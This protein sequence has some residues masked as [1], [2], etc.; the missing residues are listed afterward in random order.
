MAS[1]F[2]CSRGH[3]W[4]ADMA[5][6]EAAT[7]VLCPVCRGVGA[8]CTTPNGVN[9][10]PAEGETETIGLA[11]PAAAARA[12]LPVIAGYEV[13]EELGRGGMGVVYKARQLKLNRLVALKMVLAGAHAVSSDLLR[14]LA[15]AEAVA[16]LQ[17][18]NI[19]QVHEVGSHGGLPFISL[20]Y[21]DG[22]TLARK[23]KGTP[24]LPK[25]AAV[26][27]ATLG[28]AVQFAHQHGV[29]HRDLKPGN[30]LL[31]A[32][33]TPKIADFG[34]AK[35][36]AA[37][38][39]VTQTGAVL[40]TPSYMAPEQA[41]CKK[42]IGPAA[43]IYALG[44]ILYELLTGRPPFQA[45]TQL[46]TVL[47][48]V[49][50]EPVPPRRLQPKAPRDLETICLKCLQKEPRKRYA[51]AAALADDLDRFLGDRPILARPVG[52]LERTGRW[53]RRNPIVAGL[54]AT[55][56]AGA[57]V[58]VYFLNAERIE[59]FSNLHRAQA[60][61]ADLKVQ[62]Q[63]TSEAEQEK[64]DKL[65]QSYFDRAR[66]G[67]FSRQ[68]GQRLDGLDALAAAARIRPS[69]QLRDQAIACMALVDLRTVPSG[70]TLPEGVTCESFDPG[71]RRYAY[72]DKTGAVSVRSVGDGSEVAHR[73]PGGQ[74]VAALVFSPDG[75]LLAGSADSSLFVWDVERDQT[76][77]TL[78]RRPVGFDFSPDGR[79]AAVGEAGVVHL[80]D[81][82]LKRERMAFP[83][84]F[85]DQRL[86]FSPDGR[87]LAVTGVW[88]SSAVRVFDSETGAL[89]QE[90]ALPQTYATAAPTWHPDGERLAVGGA[91]GRVYL[92]HVPDRRM[93]AVLEGHAQDVIGA[94]FTPDGDHLLTAS[95]DGTARLWE[96]ATGR[97]LLTRVGGFTYDV[98]GDRPRLGYFT[99]RNRSI[100]FVELADDREFRSFAN[101]LSMGYGQY[102][103]A[104]L[105]PDG[106]LAAAATDDGVRLWDLASGRETTRLS[107]GNCHAVAFTPDGG[108]LLTSGAAGLLRW[109]IRV[110]P[111]APNGL[112]IGPPRTLDVLVAP[113][114]FQLAADGRTAA[115]VSEREQAVAVL[116]A[117]S[118]A[119]RPFRLYNPMASYVAISPD[120]RWA[121]SGG[122]HAPATR[123]WDAH[124]GRMVKEM[125]LGEMT[126][127]FFSPD[128]R[129]LITCRPEEYCFWDVETWQPGLR[130]P[131]EQEPYPG[132]AAFTGDGEL[133]ALELT[134]GV[135]GLLD[136]KSDR[137]VARLENPTHD[138]ASTL[139]F[140]ADGAHLMVVAPYDRTVHVWDLRR[141]R[142]HLAE[143]HLEG[144]WPAYPP[145]PPASEPVRVRQDD[146]LIAGPPVVAAPPPVVALPPLNPTHR[147]A[148]PQQIQDWIR[149]L[150][151]DDGKASAEA[152][153]ALVDVG[154]PTVAALKPAASGPDDGLARRAAEVIDQIAV[155]EALTPPRVRRKL[156][157][158]ASVAEVVA[159]LSNQS[160]VRVDYT[161]SRPADPPKKLTLDLDNIPFWEAIDR[162]CAAGD[163]TFAIQFGQNGARVQLS[164]GPR[165]R[166]EMIADA[167]PFRLQAMSWTSNRTMILSGKEPTAI[168]RLS[169]SLALQGRGDGVAG[170]GPL[171][172]QEAEDDAGQPRLMD[173]PPGP[174]PGPPGFVDPAS[175]LFAPFRSVLLKP[176]DRRGG[177]LKRLKGVLPVEVTTERRDLATATELDKAPGKTFR[178]DGVTLIVQSVQ[179]VANGPAGQQ[180]MMVLVSLDGG[181]DWAYDATSEG[182]EL[183]DGEGRRI[184]PAWVNVNHPAVPVRRSPWPA[185]LAVFG[186]APEAGFPGAVPWAVLALNAPQ[187]GW[188]A[189]AQFITPDKLDLTKAKLTFYHYRLLRTELP[190]EFHDLP[191]P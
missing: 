191:L 59:T 20:E 162:L 111:T 39:G 157:A 175:P 32:D 10:R 70:I 14:F 96:V 61:E 135:I 107:P 81:L 34:L 125:K 99:D 94:V 75:R 171:S 22:G 74:P 103:S 174:F 167:G 188:V 42:D 152:A 26:L 41:E 95:W 186:A 158:D 129:W 64:T 67:C 101:D 110:D 93:L 112:V 6:G 179:S 38:P 4:T 119:V 53:C 138:R 51:T 28:R 127:V 184:R 105:S 77:I 78:P 37:G 149:Q 168:D 122:W 114:T 12:E 104:A 126:Y 130:I 177:V 76:I 73:G 144:D 56:A 82:A 84:G 166:R 109:P 170:V 180:A 136:W 25:E 47:Q 3:Q 151:G 189:S 163:L 29:V 185:E 8:K 36:S 156:Q 85:P 13:L 106:R 49:S 113:S 54:A 183:T 90:M 48:V 153:A 17:H 142:E 72:A 178:G 190:F 131:R 63:K 148:T 19:V 45:P 120:G 65:W 88:K 52:R 86:A 155:A 27:T 124:T 68:V 150:G 55:L 92:F 161:P 60:A 160:G 58:A 44:A 137:V 9:P 91:N 139:C 169:L 1:L 147:A 87:R 62:L 18:A 154:P 23:L 16:Q 140:G 118:G 164:D 176:S 5:P 43:D 35:R 2:E 165:L 98:R 24:L 173:Q 83:T 40:G 11:A 132:P 115:V 30:V 15:E 31:T 46:D 143:M 66:A 57:L 128:S 187:P 117:E 182:F 33:G 100:Q 7:V 50:D 123:M 108:A 102:R 159:A 80:F 89:L 121:A 146:G 116:D 69:D 172:F 145:A 133:M 134:P 71:G 21:V 97:L 79:Q 181:P 141:I